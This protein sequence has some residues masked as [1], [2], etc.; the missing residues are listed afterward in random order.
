MSRPTSPLDDRDCTPPFSTQSQSSNVDK[1]YKPKFHTALYNSNDSS[2]S[3][4]GATINSANNT[5]KKE[6][7]SPIPLS[8]SPARSTPSYAS[9]FQMTQKSSIASLVTS[10]ATTSSGS[11]QFGLVR[12]MLFIFKAADSHIC[13]LLF[14]FYIFFLFF[15]CV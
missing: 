13:L 1:P 10:T 5:P 14:F 15:L 7:Q 6:N 12:L 11:G 4:T 3:S 9:N 8:M 2:C